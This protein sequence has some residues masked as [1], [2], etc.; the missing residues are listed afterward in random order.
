MMGRSISRL[1]VLSSLVLA[2]VS[3][4]DPAD[5]AGAPPADAVQAYTPS[6]KPLV[7]PHPDREAVEKLDSARI[8]YEKDPTNP[9]KLIWY[10]RRMAYTG[11][12]RS[13][14]RIFSEGIDRHPLDARMYR[15]RGHRYISVREFDRAIE[16]LERA[17]KLIEGENDSIEPDGIPNA[18][19]I[20]VSTLHGNIWYHLGLAWYLK[21]DWEKAYRA[22]QAGFDTGGNDDNRVSTAHWRYMILRRMGRT[23]EARRSLAD[24]SPDMKVIENMVYHRLCLFYKGQLPLAEMA[25]EDADNPTGAAGAYGVANWFLYNGDLQEARRRLEALTNTASWDSFGYIAA[26]A[27]LSTLDREASA[28]P[29]SPRY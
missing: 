24:I 8:E 18:L 9:D 29:G 17:V 5:V 11:D 21:H 7:S 13:A 19:N 4:A 25:A 12:Y 20:P 3:A 10:G 16:D 15:H 14:I 23:E 2:A 27:D 22:F 1:M 6:G 28:P 26:E